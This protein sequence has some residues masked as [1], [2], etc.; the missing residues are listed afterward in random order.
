MARGEPLSRILTIRVSD[1][2]YKYLRRRARERGRVR[3]RRYDLAEYLR[4]VWETEEMAEVR[5]SSIRE[6]G[7]P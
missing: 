4:E 1:R 5:T 3:G 2:T 6:E 7:A